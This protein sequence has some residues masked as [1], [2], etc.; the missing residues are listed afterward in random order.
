M[1]TVRHGSAYTVVRAMN[2]INGKCRFS[3]SCSSETLRLIFIKFGTIDYVRNLTPHAN[4][5]TN[6]VK[7][8]IAAHT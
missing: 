1:I 8:G 2:V 6:P 5:E 7:G 3:G 4:I